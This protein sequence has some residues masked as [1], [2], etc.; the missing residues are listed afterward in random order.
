MNNKEFL[1]WIYNRM[2]EVHGEK[3]N[4]DYM[5]RFRKTINDVKKQDQKIDI[6]NKVITEHT[7]IK[8]VRFENDLLAKDNI[9]GA[10]IID[11]TD[12]VYYVE[13][14]E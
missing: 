6:L 12:K 13:L 2:A 7:F 1:Q 11:V 10:R 8:E 5:A 3:I 4:T 9:V 14:G